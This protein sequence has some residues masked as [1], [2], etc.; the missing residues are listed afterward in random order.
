[1]GRGLIGAAV[2]VVK[3]LYVYSP[4]TVHEIFTVHALRQLSTPQHSMKR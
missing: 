4:N 1:M 3:V 2:M